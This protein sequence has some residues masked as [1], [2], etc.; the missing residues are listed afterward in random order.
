MLPTERQFIDEMIAKDLRL[1]DT[2]VFY[3]ASK[4]PQKH[5]NRAFRLALMLE[6]FGHRKVFV[7]DGGL[8]KWKKDGQKTSSE[9]KKPFK[10][11]F[12][13]SRVP[14]YEQMLANSKRPTS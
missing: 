9:S 12:D 2:V 3:D 14:T 7:L 4:D 1:D 6:L 5:A 10:Y 8:Q 11:D 13:E